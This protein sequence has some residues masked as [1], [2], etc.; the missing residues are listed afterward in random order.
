MLRSWSITVIIFFYVQ[1]QTL[2]SIL[3]FISVLSRIRLSSSKLSPWG[4]NQTNPSKN[5]SLRCF[6]NVSSKERRLKEQWPC[7]FCA[8]LWWFLYYFYK[9]KIKKRAKSFHQ[10]VRRALWRHCEGKD[11]REKIKI[12]HAV[13]KNITGHWVGMMM[14][15][16]MM[17]SF[18]PTVREQDSSFCS[19]GCNTEVKLKHT[20]SGRSER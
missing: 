6:M 7:L 5:I 20:L 15:L 11:E 4:Q 18:G 9:K 1:G 10:S 17:I 16:M 2:K 8:E 14:M 12:V 13:L 19:E 3:L